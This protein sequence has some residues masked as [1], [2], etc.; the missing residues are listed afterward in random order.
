M[1][2]LG[3]N[4]EIGDPAQDVFVA[5]LESIH[6]LEQPGALRGWL[7][8]IAV[9]HA[10]HCL[11]GR[12]QWSILRFFSPEH[13]PPGRARE[14]DFE[15]SEALRATYRVLSSL[16]VD[17]RI[18]FTL[19]FVEGMNLTDVAAASR[20]SLA[21]VKRRLLRAEARFAESR[22]RR[23]VAFGVGWRN[24]MSASRP[25]F[26]ALGEQLAREQDAILARPLPADEATLRE[27]V[28]AR[29]PKRVVVT[30]ALVAASFALVG[31]GAVTYLARTRPLT[32]TVG[33]DPLPNGGWISAPPTGSV[34]IRFSE[35]TEIALDPEAHARV[36]EVTQRGAHLL[37]ESG[38]AHVSVTPGRGGRWTFTA[39]P[40]QVDVKGTRFEIAWSPREQLFSLKLVEG[41]VFISGCAL[42]EGH[43]LFAGETL[44]R[45]L[46]R[47]RVSHRSGLRIRCGPC[48]PPPS[49]PLP[50]LAPS[51]LA[52]EI[53]PTELATRPG[54]MAPRALKGRI[55][56]GAGGTRRGRASRARAGSRRHSR[57]W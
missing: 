10:R 13:L 37:L 56:H 33:R 39:G 57:A 48:S 25:A 20:V 17:E 6:K 24:D 9:F 19:R 47:A 2:V 4:P 45:V 40:F 55:G 14:T 53:D 41:S 36:A 51:A 26:R 21:T 34:P 46:P 22:A 12:K 28:R 42:G 7:A 31:I 54:T 29:R 38:T 23:A 50:A 18:A 5:A 11:R 30:V 35:G 44:E 32:L 1:R 16:P 27:P 49:P 52:P 3:P 8:Q 15:A 43:P